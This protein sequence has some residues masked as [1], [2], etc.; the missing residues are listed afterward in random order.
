MRWRYAKQPGQVTAGFGASKYILM[1]RKTML[2]IDKS[3]KLGQ[4]GAHPLAEATLHR[5]RADLGAPLH[6]RRLPDDPPVH[7]T[8]FPCV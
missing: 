7:R 3:N 4:T 2:G 5:G 1:M 8:L 6:P